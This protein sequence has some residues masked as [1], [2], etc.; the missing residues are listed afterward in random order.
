MKLTT[1]TLIVA[2]TIITGCTGTPANS[3]GTTASADG[4]V[5]TY[6][7]VTGT[8][9]KTKICR[10]PEQIEQDKI[11]ADRAMKTFTRGQTKA[12]NG[13]SH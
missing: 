11:D 10:T 4:L 13:S 5:C 7:K 6:E 1:I 12:G 3:N 9:M 2:A 8:K